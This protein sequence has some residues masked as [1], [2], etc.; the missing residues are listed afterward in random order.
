ML[1]TQLS[2]PCKIRLVSVNDKNTEVPEKQE[3]GPGASRGGDGKGKQTVMGHRKVL[4]SLII[5]NSV[6]PLNH[7]AG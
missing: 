3:E 1:C 7:K 6:P 5:P 2:A 4:T